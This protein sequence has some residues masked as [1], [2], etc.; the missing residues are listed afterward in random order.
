MS[1]YNQLL[2]SF[3]SKVELKEMQTPEYL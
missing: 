3:H 1:L 2:D